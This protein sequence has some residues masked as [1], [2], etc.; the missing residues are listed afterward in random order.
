MTATVPRDAG[1]FFRI[2][3]ELIQVRCLGMAE[4]R[5]A[6]VNKVSQSIGWSVNYSVTVL[7]P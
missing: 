4:K 3:V 6:P 1:L 7:L 5:E 2:L